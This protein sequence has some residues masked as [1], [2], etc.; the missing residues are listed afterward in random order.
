M[1]FNSHSLSPLGQ[2]YSPLLVACASGKSESALELL[3]ELG[4]QPAAA[5]LSDLDALHLAALNGH[6]HLLRPLLQRHRLEPRPNRRGLR[7]LHL[8]AASQTGSLCLDLLVAHA[9]Q[10]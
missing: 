10:G 1:K 9:A 7:P 8:A 2:L 4:A 3:L 5:T 6:D